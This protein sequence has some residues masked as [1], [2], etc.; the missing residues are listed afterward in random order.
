METV[1]IKVYEFAE[2]PEEAKVKALRNN[3]DWN[4][5][6]SF[7]YESTVD[8]AKRI[9]ALFGLDIDKVY[10]SG[11]SLQGDGACFEGSFEG[12]IGGAVAVANECPEDATVQE[13]AADYESLQTANN[14]E[15]AGTV[16]HRGHYNHSGCTNIEVVEENEGDGTIPQETEASMRE[17]LRRYM[18]WIY[19][20][21]EREYEYQTSEAQ[22]IESLEANG[23]K[24]RIDGTNHH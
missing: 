1:E 24:F 21:L 15:L 7:W 22:I 8:D 12:L 14:Y 13:I 23:V 10:F 4:V 9:G 2:L 16:K 18:D 20:N 6:D 3:W 11:F 17:T 5:D 19:R